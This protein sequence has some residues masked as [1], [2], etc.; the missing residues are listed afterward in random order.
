MQ[1]GM[2]FSLTNTGITILFVQGFTHGC[3]YSLLKEEL[4]PHA[5]D[6]GL[7][8]RLQMGLCCARI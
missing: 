3:G 4:S 1:L 8:K 5:Q 6:N 7:L 2:Q